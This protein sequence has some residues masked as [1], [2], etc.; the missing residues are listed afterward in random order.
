MIKSKATCDEGTKTTTKKS[1]YTLFRIVNEKVTIVREFIIWA[2]AVGGFYGALIYLIKH[3]N[4]WAGLGRWRKKE[5]V[6]KVAFLNINAN[7]FFISAIYSN[8]FQLNNFSLK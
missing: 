8:N 5:T 2:V 3:N 6:K 7:R 4:V 1:F